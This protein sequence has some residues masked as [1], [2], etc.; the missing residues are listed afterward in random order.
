MAKGHFHS[1]CSNYTAEFCK[2]PEDQLES[3]F[4]GLQLKPEI[5][6]KFKKLKRL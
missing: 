6:E 2:T 4:L 3:F 5:S 1:C